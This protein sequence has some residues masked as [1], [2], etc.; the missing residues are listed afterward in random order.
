MKSIM[1]DKKLK[2]CYLCKLFY[3]DTTPKTVEEHHVFEGRAN[4]DMSEKYGLKVYLCIPHHRGNFKGRKLAVH[5]PDLNNYADLLHKKGQI[6]FMENW[7]RQTNCSNKDQ[8]EEIF[9]GLFGK[10]YIDE[11]DWND[12]H[13]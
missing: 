12:R 10:S 8:A 2:Q 11:E 4:R 3:G 1:Q 7:M 13:N 9:R 5:S 6:A